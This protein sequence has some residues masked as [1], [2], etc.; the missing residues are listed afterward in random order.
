MSNIIQAVS[1]LNEMLGHFKVYEKGNLNQ[2][3][4]T[5]ITDGYS[6]YVKMG[7]IY[8]L[9]DNEDDIPRDDVDAI[10]RLIMKKISTVHEELNSFIGFLGN[11]NFYFNKTIE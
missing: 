11:Y 4:L 8:L 6:E 7:D 1:D 10:C 9:D 3:T 2:F 5:Y